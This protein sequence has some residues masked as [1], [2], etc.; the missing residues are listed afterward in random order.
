MENHF[1]L[2]DIKNSEEICFDYHK[3]S[4]PPEDD[5]REWDKLR[6][7]LW[8]TLKPI[9]NALISLSQ[10][11]KL[12]SIT[13]K[14]IVEW[15]YRASCLFDAGEHHLFLDTEEGS[16]PIRFSPIDFRQHIGMLCDMPTLS[17][18]EFDLSLRDLRVK[19]ILKEGFDGF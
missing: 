6:K 18:K 4:Y 8:F 15:Y 17:N 2:T 11:V 3:G 9:T 10:D 13:N 14:N 5:D 7:N 19:N 12:D 16:V 1:D